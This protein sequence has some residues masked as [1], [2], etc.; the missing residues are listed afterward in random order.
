M[1]KRD[2]HEDLSAPDKRPR[3]RP[4]VMTPE[5]RRDRVFAALDSVFERDGLD[6]LTMNAIAAEAG[7]S[8]RTLYHLFGDRDALF[9]A[10]MERIR[11]D[12]I[13]P[14]EL[15]DLDLPFGE[16]L[17][18]L[19]APVPRNRRSGLPLAVLRM[20]IAGAEAQPQLARTCLE[21]G[22]ARDRQ[23]IR[24]EL[25]RAVARGEAVIP[26]TKTAAELLEA[27]VRPAILDLLLKPEERI[28]PEA[29]RHRFEFGLDMFLR[30]V[31][32]GEE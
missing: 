25:D 22:V 14:L 19:L 21:C 31:C 12:Y 15:G 11:S 8:K 29:M 27:M 13:R 17:R 28:S 3:G 1:R 24:A 16:R 6:G 23:S 20:A 2:G 26:D 10:Y 30:G 7:M 18:R 32:A 4:V 9:H 5:V